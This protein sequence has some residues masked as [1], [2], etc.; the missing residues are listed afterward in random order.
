[1]M[2]IHRLM[3]LKLTRQ[4]FSCIILRHTLQCLKTPLCL[5]HRHAKLQASSIYSWIIDIYISIWY[6]AVSDRLLTSLFI[7]CFEATGSRFK[8]N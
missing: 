1:M 2:F 8:I 7:S 6:L 3:L 4:N 5:G